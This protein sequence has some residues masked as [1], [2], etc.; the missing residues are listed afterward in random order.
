MKASY[1]R[2][3]RDAQ[4]LTAQIGRLARNGHSNSEV[5]ARLFISTRTVEYHLQKVFTKLNI[6]SRGQLQ[7]VLA[8]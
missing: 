1:R 8:D 6:Q 2:T 3:C 7:G 4:M 5:G